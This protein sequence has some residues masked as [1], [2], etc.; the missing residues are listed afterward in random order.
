MRGSGSQGAIE[1]LIVGP[2]RPLRPFEPDALLGRFD[3][4]PIPIQSNACMLVDSS[5]HACST[6]SYACL[7]IWNAIYTC[8]PQAVV[9]LT[10][11][12]LQPSLHA[13]VQGGS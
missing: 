7:P 12:I 4:R 9:W 8:M 13:C 10:I 1:Y 3:A 6:Y 11:G 2:L 5:M